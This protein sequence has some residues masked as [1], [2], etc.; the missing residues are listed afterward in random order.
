MPRV[1]E[2]QGQKGHHV[3]FGYLTH[4]TGPYTGDPGVVLFEYKTYAG[5]TP[6]EVQSLI[7]ADGNQWPAF[8]VVWRWNRNI[9]NLNGGRFHARAAVVPA[10]W[11]EDRLLNDED[12]VKVRAVHWLG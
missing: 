1:T 12:Y 6:E 5:A 4:K 9:K 2:F 8:N 7:D 10:E 3:W 11:T